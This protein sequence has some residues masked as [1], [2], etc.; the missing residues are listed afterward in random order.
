MF[1]FTHFF[2]SEHCTLDI[3]NEK[4]VFSTAIALELKRTEILEI[5]F[6]LHTKTDLSPSL[7]F[8]ENIDILIAPN[9]LHDPTLYI[10]GLSIYNMSPANVSLPK[11]NPSI[12]YSFL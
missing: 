12:L 9:L 8:N 3:E 10:E 1:V 11:G 4:I 6:I 7:T 2:Q 5:D